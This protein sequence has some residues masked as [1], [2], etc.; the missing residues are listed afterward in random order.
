MKYRK[1]PVVIEAMQWTGRNVGE[2]T[3]FLKGAGTF[4]FGDK[5]EVTTIHGKR[6]IIRPGDWIM[7]EPME[8]CFYPCKPDI[9]EATY[10]A[11]PEA[12]HP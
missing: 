8:G 5:I 10:D 12:S 6:A 7:P 3:A 11:V 9:F 4:V 2:A 1:K